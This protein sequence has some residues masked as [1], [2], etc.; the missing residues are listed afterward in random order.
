MQPKKRNGEVHHPTPPS[1]QRNICKSFRLIDFQVMDSSVEDIEGSTEAEDVY[2]IFSDS[3]EPIVDE[4]DEDDDGMEEEE[5][6]EEEEEDVRFR[7]KIFAIQM[8]GINEM[9]ESAC[10]TVTDYRPFFYIRVNDNWTMN[11]ANAFI[12]E[13]CRRNGMSHSFRNKSIKTYRL[14]ENNKLYGFTDN[15]QY[16][17]LWIEFENLSAFSRFRQLWYHQDKFTKKRHLGAIEFAGFPTELYES[18]ILPLLRFFHIKQMS[19]SG[20]IAVHIN[21]SKKPRYPTT[22]C[23]YEYICSSEHVVAMPDKETPVPYKVMSF[24]IETSSSHGE[25]SVPVKTYKKLAQNMADIYMNHSQGITMTME[26]A[27]MMV[28]RAVLTAFGMDTFEDVD[29]VYCQ[30]QPTEKYIRGQIERLLSMSMTRAQQMSMETADE[31]DTRIRMHT[32]QTLFAEVQNARK[33]KYIVRKNPD[34]DADADAADDD[35]VEEEEEEEEEDDMALEEDDV[36]VAPS[37][38]SCNSTSSYVGHKP[39]ELRFVDVLLSEKFSRDEKIQ[40]MDETLTCLFPPIKGDEVTFVGS[41]FLRYGEAEPYLNHCYVVGSCN[42]IADANNTIIESCNSEYDMLLAW[43]RLVNKE[44]P[45]IVI[46]YNIFGFDYHFMFQRALQLN[47][48]PQFLQLSRIRGKICATNVDDYKN[49]NAVLQIDHTSIALASGEY[50]LDYVKMP[51]RLQID[52]LMYLRREFTNFAGYKLDTMAS[53]FVS[54]DIFHV[55]SDTET[56]TTALF[57]KN[58]AGLHRG[59]YIHVEL[60]SFTSDYYAD[61]KKFVVREIEY[62]RVRADGSKFNVIVIEGGEHETV[63]KATGRKI[64]WG[65]TKDDVTAKDIFR[66]T[67]DG[68]PEGRAIVAKYCIQDCNLVHNLFKKVDVMTGFVEMSR[69]CSVPIDFLVLRGQGIKLTSYVAKKCR[70]KKTLMPDLEKSGSTDGYEGAIVLPPK[71][72]MYMDN[73]VACVDYASLYPSAMI[74]Q[75]FSHD[76]KV[77]T[78]TYDLKGKVISETGEKDAKTGEYKYDNLP[79]YQYIDITFNTYSYISK[80]PKSKAVK[81]KSGTKLCRW[82]QFPDGKK[83]IMPSILEELLKARSDTKKLMKKETDPFMQNILDKRQLGYKVTANSLYGQCGARTSTFFEQDVAASTTATGRMMITYA[84]RMIEEI[85]GNG[86]EVLTQCAGPVMTYAEYVYGDTDS[87]FFTFN[88]RDKTTGM[89][90]QGAKALEITIEIAQEA[91]EICTQYLKGPME[92]AYEKTLM[93]FILL[94]KKRYVGMLYETDPK[95]GKLKF[96]GLALKRRDSCDNVKDVYGGILNIL[97]FEHDFAKSIAFLNSCLEDL[98]GGR[99]PSDKLVLTRALGSYYKTPKQIAHWVLAERM[100]KRDPGNKPK[101]GDRIKFLHFYNPAAK[102]QGDRIETPEYIQEQ[103]LRINYAHYI[104]NQLMKPIQQLYGLALEQ[105]WSL[106]GNKVL[107]INQYRLDIAELQKKW[108]DLEVFVKRKDDYCSRRVKEILFQPW[109]QKINDQ[110]NG[111]RAIQFPMTSASTTTTKTV[112]PKPKIVLPVGKN[113][114]TNLTP[115]NNV[116]TPSTALPSPR[117]LVIPSPFSFAKKNAKN[118]G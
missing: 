8:F 58:I 83:G 3:V 68:G 55:E 31:E 86:K 26:F 113:Q 104:T 25:M 27:T 13:L 61:G 28:R 50:E 24:D 46:G 45:D 1:K 97:M 91:A 22:T 40:L 71:C 35:D 42:Q 73:P 32:L 56:N 47:C 60:V 37:L 21:Q 2:G 75:N 70:E 103:G 4:E 19:P 62:G 23:T 67:K 29:V 43:C 110:I 48:A 101:P 109:L 64:R 112:K 114:T 53:T 52:L 11:T 7:R 77:F 107:T 69:I 14:I 5:T 17:F 72:S 54:D 12:D 57:T 79:G 38:F 102:L 18:T 33:N 34:A 15:K 111:K 90:I 9:G 44:N 116:S 108:T 78:R 98:I 117:K 51:G 106:Q 63:L 80:T 30:R 88:L 96:M 94:K 87:V 93:P 82:A 76:S 66:L 99:V 59:D 10:I 41:T 85:Y 74:S 36:V 39:L 115:T 6:G 105:I 95:K 100:G 118:T 20:W 16:T 49:K 92:L 84:Q 81:T 89:P 65:M